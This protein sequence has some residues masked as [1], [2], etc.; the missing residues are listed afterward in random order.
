MNP[1]SFIPMFIII[2]L[3]VLWAAPKDLDESWFRVTTKYELVVGSKLQSGECQRTK[4][5]VEAALRH[6]QKYSYEVTCTPLND[7]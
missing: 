5:L 3:I 1:N 6:S 7:K 4:T 2:L